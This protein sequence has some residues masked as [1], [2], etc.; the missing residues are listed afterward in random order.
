MK[1][2]ITRKILFLGVLF[3]ISC[4]IFGQVTL[5]GIVTDSLTH[6]SLIGASVSIVGTSQGAA[7]NFNGEY[8]IA[9]IPQGE[10]TVRVSYIGYL[11]KNIS[12]SF[13]EDK[14]VELFIQ[15]STTRIEGKTIVVTAQAQGQLGAIN[16]QLSSPTITNVVSAD[17]I[18]QLPD[19]NAATALSR[20]PGVSLMNGDQVVIR[21]VEAKLNQVLVNGIQMPSTDMNNRSTNLGFISSNM[22]SGIE[23]IKA[24]TPDMDANTVGGVVNLKLASAQPGLHFDVMAQGNYNSSDRTTNTYKMWGSI[25]DR[26]FDDQ[27]GVFIQGNADR[28][29]GGNQLA[30]LTLT[31]PDASGSQKRGEGVYK[32]TAANFEFDR[33]IVDTRGGSIILDYKLPHGKIVMQNTYAATATDQRNNTIALTFT[34]NGSITYGIDR[35]KYGKEL[36][37]NSLQVENSFDNVK[38]EAS[39]SHSY[40]DQYTKIAYNNIGGPWISFSNGTNL[41]NPFNEPSGYYNTLSQQTTMPLSRTYGIFDNI[42]KSDADSSS[43]SGW[44]GAYSNAFKQHLYNASLDASVPVAFSNDVNAT[45]KVGGK[46]VRTSRTNDFQRYFAGQDPYAAVTE[47]FPGY[48]LSNAKSLRFSLVRENNFA[49]GKYF[50]SDE[51]NFNNGF[52]NVVNTDIYDAFLKKAI[53]GW[54]IPL[55]K[56]QSWQDDWM[57]AESFSAGYAMATFNIFD[58]ITL[59]GGVRFES[60]NMQYHAQYTYVIHNVDGDAIS[61]RVGTIAYDAPG[62]TLYHSVPYSANNVNRTDNNV[63]PDVQVKYKVNEW[64]DLR[65][66]YT[67][68]IA[69]PDYASINPKV[70][71]DATGRQITMG[72]PLLRPTKAQNIDV[73]LS[74]YSNKVGLFTINGFYKELKDVI[75][76]TTIY[77]G[78]VSKYATAVPIPDSAFLQNRFNYQFSKTDL[79]QTDINNTNKAY[80]RGVEIDWQTN[81]WYLPE[82]FNSLVLDVNYTKSSS[83][84]DYIN[85]RSLLA[86]HGVDKHGHPIYVDSTEV[87]DYSGGLVQQANDVVNAALGIDYKGF[88]GRLSFNMRGNV[89]NSVN[90][91]PEQNSYTG[92]IYRWDFVIKQNLPVDGLSISLNGVNI[93]HNAIRNYQDYKLKPDQQITTNGV[94]TTIP[95]PVTQNLVQVLYAPTVFQL[96]LR[97]TF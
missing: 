8:K 33:D 70:S 6:E 3:F 80:I 55:R 79:V 82:P 25:S 7:T 11:T 71:I 32:T 4:R 93:F 26:F 63:F 29:D 18:R 14:T 44:P 64:S 42:N 96:N 75:Y 76:N 73:I 88:S 58:N 90:V 72:N 69:R 50:L 77:Y 83:H 52:N 13:K 49:R 89:L 31:G 45:F 16:Q 5:E 65:L 53:S 47:Y 24:I 85:L 81:F 60:Y 21:G 43:L 67:T 84:L 10:R 27:L 28:T 19:D 61:T 15:M 17:K 39:L 54:V 23:V 68:G 40:T 9:N 30:N 20:L 59:L 92:N 57:G 87:T 46:F 48:H 12:I 41:N 91:R 97:Y 66:A 51:Y 38:V 95:T 74:V 1:I 37:I 2:I 62:A 34:G 35:N 56:D 78:Q 86:K 22:L 36:W 94:T